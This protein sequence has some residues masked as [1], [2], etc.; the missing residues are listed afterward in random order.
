M[1]LFHSIPTSEIYHCAGLHTHAE[2]ESK[3]EKVTFYEKKAAWATDETVSTY[4]QHQ[5]WCLSKQGSITVKDLPTCITKAS[6]GDSPFLQASRNKD[7]VI[8]K[9]G[10][11]KR[12]QVPT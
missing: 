7:T 4:T 3:A 6:S 10:P 12:R 9:G 11:E 8:S 2:E 1:T 5:F